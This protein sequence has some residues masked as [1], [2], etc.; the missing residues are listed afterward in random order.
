MKKIKKLISYIENLNIPLSFHFLTFFAF[1]T[2]R[3]FLEIFSDSAIVSFK[4]FPFYHRLFFSAGVSIAVSFFHYYLF[5]I[6]L[7]LIFAIIFSFVTKENIAKTMRIALSFACVAIFTPILDLIISGGK[8]INITYIYPKGLSSI[9]PLPQGLTPGETLTAGII[10]ILAFIYCQIKTKRISKAILGT[11]LIYLVILLSSILPFLINQGAKFLQIEIGAITPV[12]LIRLLIIIIL[13]ELACIAYLKNKKYSLAFL[14][15]MG[16]LKTLIFFLGFILGILLFKNH[17]GKFLLENAAAFLLSLASITLVWWLANILGNL[18]NEEKTELAAGQKIPPAGYR[19]I[20]MGIFSLACLCA[21]AV[22]FATFY[23]I[24]LGAAIS[25]IYCVRPLKLK[26][27]PVFS[28]VLISSNLLLAVILGW[29]FGGGEILEFPHIFSLYFLIFFTVCLNFVDIKDY[30]NDLASGLKTLPVIWGEKLSKLFIGLFFLISY[31]LIPWLFLEKILFFPS[32]CLGILQFY[33]I[34]RKKYQE[35]YVF[36]VLLISLIG[37]LVWLNFSPHYYSFK[38]T[39]RPSGE[40]FKRALPLRAL[41][42]DVKKGCS[43]CHSQP[44]QQK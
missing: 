20:A 19:K 21:I 12:P 31:F 4:L 3:N 29:L 24:L 6:G 33:L 15:E 39:V 36:L 27:F 11:G 7:I 8:G 9:L 14:K 5:W 25:V 10:L 23:F 43:S 41:Q 37:L 1:I 28:K 30:A 16:Y 2:I 22:N 34:N 44:P 38:V 13:G 17:I 35:K 40:K 42:K 32:L 18:E 26:R